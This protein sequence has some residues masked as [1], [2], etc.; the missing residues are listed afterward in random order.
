MKLTKRQLASRANGRR[1]RGPI[2][3]EGKRKASLNG[4]RHGLLS[5]I[6]VLP[7]ECQ[8]AFEILLDQY[9]D[10][11][12]PTD[13]AE[14]TCVEELAA[15]AWRLKRL[16]GVEKTLW[17]EAIANHKDPDHS[18]RIAHAFQDL[19]RGPE[20][21]LLHRYEARLNNAHKRALNNFFLLSD[22]DYQTNPPSDNPPEIKAPEPPS[23]P[24]EAPPPDPPEPA[25]P[26]AT[27]APVAPAAAQ[28]AYRL[29]DTVQL[30]PDR[31]PIRV[32]PFLLRS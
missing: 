10:K 31:P 4:L 24:A 14:F 5:D 7:G 8:E 32:E 25:A 6:V 29:V 12:A 18:Q 28:P 30:H 11:L 13:G 20:L 27:P 26:P 17:S 3:E 15:T 16:W 23:P 22:V 9:V 21:A 1:S 2:T 19:A